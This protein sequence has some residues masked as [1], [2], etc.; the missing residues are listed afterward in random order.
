MDSR[1]A[2]AKLEKSHEML[3]QEILSYYSDHASAD[4]EITDAV[5]HLKSHRLLNRLI[6][7]AKPVSIRK[8]LSVGTD[9]ASGLSYVMHEGKKLF[10][11]QL[12]TA[13]ALKYKYMNLMEEQSPHSPH[14]YV[15]QD[16]DVDDGSVLY[17]IGSAEGIFA[18][19]NVERARHIV[20]FEGDEAWLGAL[21]AT[22]EPW[23]EIGRAH[24]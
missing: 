22:F 21:R 17:D 20:L 16:F 1:I 24:V 3:R 5:G 4:K 10:F 13:K 6:P 7:S 14:L 8:K 11:K 2:K 18:L 23:K 9:R 12:P 19:S 15:T